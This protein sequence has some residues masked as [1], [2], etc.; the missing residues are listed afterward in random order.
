MRRAF[1]AEMGVETRVT[2]DIREPQKEVRAGETLAWKYAKPI[3]ELLATNV[4]SGETQEGYETF[5]RHHDDWYKRDR[6][7][8]ITEEQI[9]LQVQ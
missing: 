9:D 3:E 2:F 4:S 7:K 8:D 1:K 6:Q 5:N